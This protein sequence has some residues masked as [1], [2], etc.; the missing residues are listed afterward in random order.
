VFG[1]RAEKQPLASVC[2]GVT[3]SSVNTGYPQFERV[4]H[5]KQRVIHRHGVWEVA[6]EF[7]IPPYLG[8]T[9][10]QGPGVGDVDIGSGAVETAGTDYLPLL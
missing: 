3:M 8:D 4:I 9:R 1:E 5:R 6:I 10:T 7:V 2:V